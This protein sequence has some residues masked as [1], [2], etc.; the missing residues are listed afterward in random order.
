MKTI[1]I[2]LFGFEITVRKTGAKTRKTDPLPEIK[3]DNQDKAAYMDYMN[4][5]GAMD[6]LL[7]KGAA[8]KARRAAMAA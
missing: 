2:N 1:K 4:E 5:S 3:L 6:D 8:S 7:K